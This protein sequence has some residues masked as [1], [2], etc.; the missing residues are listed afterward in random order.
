MSR[1]TNPSLVEN[2]PSATNSTD[3]QSMDEVPDLLPQQQDD[4][5]FIN[6][7]ST[8]AFALSLTQLRKILENYAS[9][10]TL[11]RLFHHNRTWVSEVRWVLDMRFADSSQLLES[12]VEQIA[13]RINRSQGKICYNPR[14]LLQKKLNTIGVDLMPDILARLSPITREHDSESTSSVHSLN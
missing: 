13:D 8:I 14:G 3:N 5:F 7:P 12:L 4:N 9:N 1:L 10:S 2:Q 11:M 6:A